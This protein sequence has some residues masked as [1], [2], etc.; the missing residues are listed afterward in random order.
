[1][2]TDSFSLPVALNG[3]SYGRSALATKRREREGTFLLMVVLVTS[4]NTGRSRMILPKVDEREGPT[5]A[6]EPCLRC[7]L[8]AFSSPLALTVPAVLFRI[9]SCWGD[10]LSTDGEDEEA[11][12]NALG[13]G[14]GH[15]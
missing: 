8:V 4:F 15:C 6:P 12:T 14:R 10:E 9:G 7:L 2:S 13:E 5:P 11:T 3:C 1:M